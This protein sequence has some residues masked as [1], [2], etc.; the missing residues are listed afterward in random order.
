MLN[1]SN[2]QTIT[3]QRVVDEANNIREPIA[4][5]DVV[6]FINPAEA[7]AGDRGKGFS[8]SGTLW[9]RRGSDLRDADEV[10]VAQGVFGVVGG[11]VYDQ[12]N[13]MTGTDYGWVR[14]TI[15]RG[16]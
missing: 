16:G 3:P 11:P 14:Y 10:V 8:Q 1:I 13:P 15:R 2:F 4:P 6:V 9:T 5:I 7:L 12:D